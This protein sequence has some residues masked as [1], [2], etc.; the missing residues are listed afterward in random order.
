M[1]R[2]CAFNHNLLLTCYLSIQTI[3][4]VAYHTYLEQSD[5]KSC[6]TATAKPTLSTTLL[7]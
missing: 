5:S 6:I 4:I 3:L 2:S 7:A 1:T